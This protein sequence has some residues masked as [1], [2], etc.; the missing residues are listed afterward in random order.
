MLD[1]E[2]LQAFIEG[3]FGYGSWSAPIWFVGMEEEGGAS[4]GEIALRL[5]AWSARGR[6]SLEDLVDYY[7][8]FGV[9][10]YFEDRPARQ[11]T[12]GPLLQ[13]TW[14]Q[15]VR[16]LLGIHGDHPSTERIRQVQSESL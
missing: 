13:P 14:K 2:L 3:F 5:E 11:R 16:V 4:A 1:E 6:K 10:K 8:A 7:R 12:Y 9:A 15:L